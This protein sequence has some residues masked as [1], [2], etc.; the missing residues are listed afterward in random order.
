LPK[1]AQFSTP[2]KLSDA[3]P[4]AWSARV[5]ELF[6]P[7]VDGHLPQFYDPTQ[8][9]TPQS[10][11]RPML[12][13]P[14]FPGHL[15]KKPRRKSLKRADANRT[16]QDEYCEWVV[17]REGGSEHGKIT[18][19]TFTTE[20]PEY[21]EH[22]FE[23]NRNRLLALY[24]RFIDENVQPED[25][26]L[27]NGRYNPANRWNADTPG[28]IAHLIQRSNNLGAA[29]DLVANATIP[30]V[31]EHGEP[32]TNQQALVKCA[33]MGD[34]RR[35]SDPQIASA[36]NVEAREGNEISLADPLGLYLGPP[37]TARMV[38][39]DGV[40]AARFWKIER[41]DAE[42]TLRARFEVSGN[43]DYVVGDIEIDGELIEFGGQVAERVTVWVKPVIKSARHQP[44]AQPC[45][46]N[47]GNR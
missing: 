32:V 31:D 29:I 17:E 36:A 3:N 34:P 8:K 19:I 23:T 5:S 11:R 37:R 39:P 10:A 12:S 16:L 1:L 45:R 14:A 35:H 44:K 46:L 43:R 42:H 4:A 38:T 28:R 7:Y 6:A 2:A 33:D 15:V 25:L 30:R 26:Q 18:R 20:V 47:P 21:W 27:S 40:D 41:G 13:W 22:L 24:R 9:S